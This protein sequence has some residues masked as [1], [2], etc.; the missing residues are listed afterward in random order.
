MSLLI[1]KLK[2][3]ENML[4]K[5]T[6]KNVHDFKVIQDNVE[7]IFN[8][9][10]LVKIHNINFENTSEMREHV[11]IMINLISHK[12]SLNDKIINIF[13]KRKLVAEIRIY[14][15]NAVNKKIENSRIKRFGVFHDH[16]RSGDSLSYNK[17]PFII[18]THNKRNF[19]EFPLLFFPNSSKGEELCISEK[20]II[21]KNTNFIKLDLPFNN[22]SK[23]KQNCGSLSLDFLCLEQIRDKEI[24]FSLSEKMSMVN[25]D[26]NNKIE[27]ICI[28]V[29]IFGIDDFSQIKTNFEEISK[30]LLL[31]SYLIEN[32]PLLNQ[33]SFEFYWNFETY[34]TIEMEFKKI[35]TDFQKK[36][37]QERKTFKNIQF[38]FYLINFVDEYKVIKKVSLSKYN[39]IITLLMIFNNTRFKQLKKKAIL[40]CINSFIENFTTFIF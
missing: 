20:K 35:F 29:K 3:Q 11:Q 22:F 19:K 38:N 7:K 32:L 12:T 37:M 16:G 18:L 34:S 8:E 15:F 14:N 23:H 26:K 30:I 33:I 31:I 39:N 25:F 10:N 27:H 2:F 17:Y 1:R 24:P 6:Y 9:T 4:K 13:L 28:S 36:L 40:K 21:S 5:E